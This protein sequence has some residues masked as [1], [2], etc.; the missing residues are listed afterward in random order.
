MGKE[1]RRP[2]SSMPAFVTFIYGRIE[3]SDKGPAGQKT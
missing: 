2:Q 1:E 3:L